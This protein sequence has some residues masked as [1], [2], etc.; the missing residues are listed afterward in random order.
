MLCDNAIEI[1][2]D[3][4]SEYLDAF[5]DKWAD[6]GQ[7]VQQLSDELLNLDEVADAQAF[8]P[9]TALRVGIPPEDLKVAIAFCLQ[10]SLRSSYAG[11][12]VSVAYSKLEA[13]KM[14]IEVGSGR[15]R[16]PDMTPLAATCKRE[17]R[18]VPVAINQKDA[19]Q[20]VGRWGASIVSPTTSLSE[21]STAD[22]WLL[23]C[24]SAA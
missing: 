12:I 14:M 10:E 3:T 11:K 21:A 9:S 17:G 5:R 2:D 18:E 23:A 13:A 22:S 4:A 1:G 16:S 15:F 24:P 8:A 19:H 6:V 20:I 7:V